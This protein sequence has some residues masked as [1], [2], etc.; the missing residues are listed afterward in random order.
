MSGKASSSQ[1]TV[2]FNGSGTL[3]HVYIKHP[4]LKCSVPGSSGLFYDDGNKLLLSP[5]LNQ[6][7][8]IVEIEKSFI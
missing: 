8:W 5:K 2:G 7:N 4:P 6:V 1:S 3:S